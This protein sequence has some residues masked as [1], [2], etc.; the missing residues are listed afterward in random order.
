METARRRVIAR[1]VGD[2][3]SQVMDQGRCLGIMQKGSKLEALTQL[4]EDDPTLKIIALE[5]RDESAVCRNGLF[6]IFRVLQE[7]IDDSELLSDA[8]PLEI[9]A[10][11]LNR[12]LT[13][14]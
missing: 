2:Q 12:I 11:K 14:I 8:E 3:D 10:Q 6:G 1:Y 9:P 7:R 13:N 4:A 5:P